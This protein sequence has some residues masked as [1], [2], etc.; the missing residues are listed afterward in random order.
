MGVWLEGKSLANRIKEEVRERVEYYK[1]ETNQ[2]PGLIGI[3]VG[4]DRA[5]QVYL[6]TKEKNSQKLGINSEILT[7]PK[8]IKLEKLKAEIERLN[9]RDDVDGILVQLPLPPPLNPHEVITAILPE[10]D[11]DGF[12]PFSLGNLLLNKRGLRPCT[13]CGIIELLKA[14]NITIEGKRVVIIGRSLIVGKPLAAMMTNENGT[15]TMCHS[16]TKDLPAVASE[17]DILVAALGKGAF[18]TP[19]FVKEGATVIDVG[20]NHTSDRKRVEELFGKDEEREKDLSE[21]GYTII[22]DVHPQVIE[23]AA[24][25]TPVPGGVGALTVAMLMQNTLEAF[26]HRRGLQER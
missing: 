6:R 16:K 10:K 15:V 25:L 5:S 2:V 8:D 17:A 24:Y 23:K 9:Q 7:Y 1:R 12:H 22:G 14:H 3:L 11:V 26:I 20:I 13:P 19:E 21:K 4:D 18:V